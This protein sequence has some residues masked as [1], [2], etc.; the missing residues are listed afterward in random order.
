M[1]FAIYVTESVVTSYEFETEEE[2]RQAMANGDFWHMESEV[3]DAEVLDQEI[4]DLRD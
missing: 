1:S 2:A 3:V 4:V